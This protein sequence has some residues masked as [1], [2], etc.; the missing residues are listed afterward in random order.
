[1]IIV[2]VTLNAIFDIFADV[3]YDK[4]IFKQNVL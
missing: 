2:G 3:T 4:I 1:M